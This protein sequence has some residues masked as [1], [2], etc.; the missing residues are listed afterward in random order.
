MKKTM[1]WMTIRETARQV[2]SGGQNSSFIGLTS[3]PEEDMLK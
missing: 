2:Q 3:R 1:T